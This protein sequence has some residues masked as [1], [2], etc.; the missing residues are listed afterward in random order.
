MTSISRIVSSPVDVSAESALLA[1]VKREEITQKG[2]LSVMLCVTDL[3]RNLHPPFK[4]SDFLTGKKGQVKNASKAK[5][6]KILRRHG[7]E[8]VLAS[9][10]G[11]TSRG[12]IARMEAYLCLLNELAE[13]APL[14][15]DALE[16]FWVKRIELYFSSEPLK[17]KLDGAK[18]L[19]QL[20]SDLMDAAFERQRSCQGVMVAGAVMQYL[21]GA[22]LSIMLD[23]Q[24]L[25]QSGASSADAPT[26]RKGDFEI[27]DAVVHVTTAPTEG[28]LQK[29]ANNL[30]S[31]L[32]PIIITTE[33]G[34][35]G[36]RALAKDAEIADRVDI[37]EIEQFITTN[38]YEWSHFD[39][40]SR[41]VKIKELISEYNRIVERLE[42]DH[43]LKINLD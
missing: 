29:C 11:R 9:E 17:V 12:N 41:P 14:N 4:P 40:I 21:V 26:G 37:L 13:K 24:Y 1:L 2:G 43:S 30:A 6:Q 31:N 3:A 39:H 34:A 7:I 10:A 19:R 8:R 25:V 23:N 18:S 22:K 28:L 33:E 36:A 32:R 20:V 16:T 15:F 42:T 27:G 38:V 5:V 35:G